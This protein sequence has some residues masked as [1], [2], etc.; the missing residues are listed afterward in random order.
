M[1]VLPTFA[2]I[3]AL[4]LLGSCVKN[5]TVPTPESAASALPQAPVSHCSREGRLFD[6]GTTLIMPDGVSVWYKDTGKDKGMPLYI[7]H[8]G[9]GY[10]S[11]SFEKSVGALLEREFRVVYIDQRGSGRSAVDASASF[12]MATT[13]LDV[14]RIRSQLGHTRIGLLGHS[15][16]GAVAAEY[17]R[18]FPERVMSVAFVETTPN[19]AGSVAQQLAYVGANAPTLF[20]ER[21]PE[22]QALMAD[23]AK[24]SLDRL[25]GLYGLV[26]R[27]RLQRALDFPS[28]EA[29]D[30]QEALDAL[31]GL[32]PCT[33]RGVLEAYRKEGY[34]DREMPSVA[35]AIPAKS[36]L[37][38]GRQSKVIGEAGYR[39][40]AEVWGSAPVAL[41]QSGH[42]P[43]ADEPEAFV[44]LLRNA[45]AGLR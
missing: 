1:T 35:F 5:G 27:Q 25:L 44:N 2:A 6:G 17:T 34:F 4:A 39:R 42:F 32:L 38:A 16:G 28:Q 41:E 22:I 18:R 43:Y 10:N 21:A 7:L 31:S 15:F 45:F 19:L 36:L 3:L 30:K 40:A 14:E 29:Q 9:P 11:Y 12:G 33:Q 24:P 37:I 23:E 26:T 8:G 20:P 13:V